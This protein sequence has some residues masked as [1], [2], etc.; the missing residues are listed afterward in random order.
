[1][2]LLNLQWLLGRW[3]EPQNNTHTATNDKITDPIT[4]TFKF[5]HASKQEVIDAISYLH[6]TGK[7]SEAEEMAECWA[8]F[9]AYA[10]NHFGDYIP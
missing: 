2:E 8:A 9:N 1:M 6:Q 5:I 7:H 3:F 10:A 4:R